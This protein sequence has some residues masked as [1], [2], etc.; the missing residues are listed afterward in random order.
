M[1]KQVLHKL[2]LASAGAVGADR[3]RR[4]PAGATRSPITTPTASPIWKMPAPRAVQEAETRGGTG[5]FRAIQETFEAD[6]H[7]V[8]EQALYRHLALPPDETGRHDRLCRVQLVS[9][10]HLAA[11][12]AA[13]GSRRT[14]HPAHGGLSLSRTWRLVG[15]SGRAK[16]QR[17]T[18]A[19]LFRPL[20]FGRRGVTPDDQVGAL[21]GIGNNA[22]AHRPA[23][24]CDPGV[25]FRRDRIGPLIWRNET[26][27]GQPARQRPGVFHR[28]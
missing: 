23:R 18:L 10:P 22:L 1:T 4:W 5:D 12:M 6:A 16:R 21:V 28:L 8:P 26:Q 27:S 9:L 14:G 19:S 11:S 13:S 7:G 3:L 2:T 24:A 20:C 15:L 25:R 17:R